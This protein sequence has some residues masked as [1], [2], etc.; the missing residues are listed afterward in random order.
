MVKRLRK[1]GYT[2]PFSGGK[3]QFMRKDTFSARLPSDHG[4]D[5]SVPLLHK[6][7]N[8]WGV[9]HDEWNGAA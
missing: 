6:L 3:H 8:Q 5:I 1:L 2:G 7:L 4:G 9:T